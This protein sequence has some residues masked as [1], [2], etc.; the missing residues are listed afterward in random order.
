MTTRQLTE[1]LT[2]ALSR[3]VLDKTSLVGIYDVTLQWSTDQAEV[4]LPVVQDS[5]QREPGNASWP[6]I[7]VAI[8]EQLG[9]KLEEGKGPVEVIVIDY[10]E[11]PSRN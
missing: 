4:P 1:M 3:T 8:Q 11:R 10:V 7:F 6:S 9:L 5:G 2:L